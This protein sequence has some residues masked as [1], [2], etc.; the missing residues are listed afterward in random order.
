MLA[1]KKSLTFKTCDHDEYTSRAIEMIEGCTDEERGF[2][3]KMLPSVYESYSDGSVNS[4]ATHICEGDS[5]NCDECVDSAASFLAN[6]NVRERAFMVSAIE[7]SL[8][9]LR[10]GMGFAYIPFPDLEIHPHFFLM[11]S[12]AEHQLSGECCE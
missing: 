3:A 4:L 8:E 12:A 10:S 6:L 7:L 1:S 11:A 9:Q 5:M 2:V